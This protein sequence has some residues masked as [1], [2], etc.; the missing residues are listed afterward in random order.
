MSLTNG[1]DTDEPTR[2]LEGG[3]TPNSRGEPRDV[4]D[5]TAAAVGD[6]LGRYQLL[7]LLGKG[8]MGLVFRARDPQLDRDVALKVLRAA[9]PGHERSA[10][11]ARMLREARAMAA[12]HHPN[13]IDVF[14]VGTA[15]GSV[16]FAMELIEGQTLDR[17]IADRPG[18]REVLR[19]FDAA[20][21]G[22]IAAHRVGLVHRDFKPGNVLLDR[23]G[24]V[25]VTDFGIAFTTNDRESCTPEPVP[26][27]RRTSESSLTATGTVMGTPAYMSPEQHFG[28]PVTELSDQFSF[29]VT[30][31][32]A[33]YGVRP[34][35][36][37]TAGSIARDIERGAFRPVPP[38]AVPTGV[39]RVLERGLARRP[40]DRWPTLE[41][42]LGELRRRTTGGSSS[43]RRAA[44]LGVGAIIV[45]LGL[46]VAPNMS[47]E[48]QCL[49]ATTRDPV[50]LASVFSGA[51][52]ASGAWVVTGPRL[53]AYR[54]TLSDARRQVCAARSEGRMHADEQLSCL[55]ARRAEYEG[56]IDLLGEGDS[57]VLE[58][59]DALVRGLTPAEDCLRTG[60]HDDLPDDPALAAEAVELERMLARVRLLDGAGRYQEG[61][62]LASE[63]HARARELG[64]PRILAMAMYLDARLT[65]SNGNADAS[66][67]LLEDAAWYALDVGNDDIALRAMS[68]LVFTLATR[69]DRVDDAIDWGER[70]K[71]VAARMGRDQ[72]GWLYSNLGVALALRGDYDEARAAH[73]RALELKLARQ[74]PNSTDVAA[75]RLN[76]VGVLQHQGEHVEARAQ[77]EEGLRVYREQGGDEHPDTAVALMVLA[78]TQSA[79]G[80]KTAAR[81]SLDEAAV[82]L[83]RT[84]PD[85]HR[86]LIIARNSLGLLALEERRLDDARRHFTDALALAR[87]QFEPTHPAVGEMR[88]NLAEVDLAEGRLDDAERGFL[89]AEELFS[90]SEGGAQSRD[91]PLGGLV[92]VALKRGDLDEAQRRLDEVFTHFETLGEASLAPE[93]IA[94]AHHQLGLVHLRRGHKAEA[95]A[96]LR[97]AEAALTAVGRTTREL[98]DVRR[99]L[100]EAES[101]S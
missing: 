31:W 25:A 35:D 30:L 81:E 100:V 38:S 87:E 18:W 11:Q 26:T 60:A 22:L 29:C 65:E 42:L 20:G 55:E 52:G 98:D 13:V 40:E 9:R 69:L 83:K 88:H 17:W 92:D 79:Q 85:D 10:G 2:E 50:E 89:Q 82:I 12:I 96:A 99:A 15:G 78:E 62:E 97:T 27:P 86:H 54:E 28:E 63:V 32:K 23:G 14:D 8:G 37:S 70:A 84:L 58:R 51:P 59:A 39:R 48:D 43:R 73:L 19:V 74:G 64:V 75:A 4:E 21:R 49:S 6:E 44:V 41:T 24:R 77:I 67:P 45:A 33:L 95:I 90:A 66:A 80:E 68:E 1:T 3:P 53:S 36:G 56:L 101:E 5:A 71:P 46:A 16:F 93:Q 57:A 94:S 76:Y 91:R 61:H 47:T 72:G 34:F 7:E